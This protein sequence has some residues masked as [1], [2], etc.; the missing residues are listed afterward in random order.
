MP[1]LLRILR[2]IGWRPIASYFPL[3][4]IFITLAQLYALN[5]LSFW[6]FVL[7]SFLC[8]IILAWILYSS[9]INPL[10]EVV[11]IAKSVAGENFEQYVPAF[12]N[13]EIGDL[14]RS[15]NCMTK[16]L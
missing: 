10:K 15:I 13:N 6:A 12:S 5:W 8:T 1:A 2:N 3:L 7:L 11:S 16:R 9:L 14:A 4:I